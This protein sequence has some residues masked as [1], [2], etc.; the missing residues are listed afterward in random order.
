MKRFVFFVLFTITISLALAYNLGRT[1]VA[2][3]PA[4]AA[5]SET[6]ATVGVDQLMKNVDKHR[7]SINVEGVVSAVSS[8][9]HM[10]SLIDTQEFNKCA[11]V[12]CATLTLPVRWSGTMPSIK[13]QVRIEGEIKE[14]RGKLFF[15]AKT[16]QGAASQS[17]GSK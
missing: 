12:T 16:L 2:L 5:E 17:G 8:K 9:D 15:E 10:L 14:N 6:G 7:G 11:V 1:G 13:D 4:Y 3:P